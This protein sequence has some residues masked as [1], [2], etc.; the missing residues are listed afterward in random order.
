MFNKKKK[1]EDA[2]ELEEF[3]D[4]DLDLPEIPKKKEKEK[5]GLTKEEVLSLAEYHQARSL[6]L[7]NLFRRLE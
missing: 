7:I 2:D 3:E 6:E 1:E 4:D 5:K